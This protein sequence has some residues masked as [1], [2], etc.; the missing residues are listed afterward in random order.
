MKGVMRKDIEA[1]ETLIMDV[2][3]EL[4]QH[5][6]E[7]DDI[8]AAVNSIEFDL[9]EVNSGS[10]PAGISVFLKI[11]RK[12]NYDMMPESALFF[13]EALMTVKKDIE[14]DGSQ[15][16]QDLIQEFLVMNTHRVHMQLHP[17]VNYAKE[18]EDEETNALATARARLSKQEYDAIVV[19][20]KQLFDIQNTEEKEFNCCVLCA[21]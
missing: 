14:R 18:Q 11:M 9:R 4:V 19:Q 17:D 2:L 7:E 21:F 12:W 6:F 16:F 5:G 3:K 20:G 1:L 13:E 15:L 10:E 8:K